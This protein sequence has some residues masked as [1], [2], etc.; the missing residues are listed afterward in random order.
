ML[1][2][3]MHLTISTRVLEG[4]SDP[5]LTR[6]DIVFESRTDPHRH[7]MLGVC[8][9]VPSPLP[10]FGKGCVFFDVVLLVRKEPCRIQHLTNLQLNLDDMLVTGHRGN[11]SRNQRKKENIHSYSRRCCRHELQ[12]PRKRQ[13][14][15]EASRFSPLFVGWRDTSLPSVCERSH[16]RGC[17]WREQRWSQTL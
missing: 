5:N 6:I 2:T 9:A 11:F 10:I 12:R 13:T 17:G 16:D 8:G 14:R 15:W 3:C 1:R 7:G 4:Q